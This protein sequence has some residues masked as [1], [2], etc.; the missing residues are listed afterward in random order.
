[1]RGDGCSFLQSEDGKVVEMET[2]MSRFKK[3]L[4][5]K[6]SGFIL[7]MSWTKGMR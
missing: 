6:I 7:V 3:M 4:R 2:G 5:N 1:M